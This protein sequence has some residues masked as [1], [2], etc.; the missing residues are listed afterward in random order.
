VSAAVLVGLAIATASPASAENPVYDADTAAEIAAAFAEATEVQGVCYAVS[1]NVDDYDT[2]VYEGTYVVSSAG[3]DQRPAEALCSRGS[4]EL[5]A[6]V[7]YVSEYTEAE[8][9]ASW[10][11]LSTLGGF[12]EVDLARSGFSA[13]SL[14]KDD[15][16]EQVLLN[17]ALSLPRLTA[18]TVDGVP[19]LVLTPSTQ[20]PPSDAAATNRPGSD[21]FR[22]HKT[23][24]V[25]LVL[26]AL[27]SSL[28]AY[29]LLR[30]P[31]RPWSPRSA[32]THPRS[33][34][35]PHRHDLPTPEQL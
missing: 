1:L 19:P 16:S 6:T 5:Q 32:Y 21:R 23:E 3:V 15:E 24:V 10:F 35:D 7:R 20:A 28:W 34:N 33:T 31:R 30:R 27:G 4:V 26:V 13:G 12:G 22:Q 17:A 2:G 14:L 9:S 18:E 8:D 11:V 25:L 29:T